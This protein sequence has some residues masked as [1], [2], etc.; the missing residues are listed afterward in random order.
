MRQ[1]VLKFGFLVL[2][3]LALLELARY[4]L[5]TRRIAEDGLTVIFAL[6]FIGVGWWL[7]RRFR[8]TVTNT[9]QGKT[10]QH[11]QIFSQ[12]K[13]KIIDQLG[14]S[15]RELEVLPLIA[16]GLSNQEIANRLFIAE[17]TVKSHVSNIM[18][19]LEVNRRTQA[20]KKARNLG[21]LV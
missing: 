10:L 2:A 12:S 7:S 3:I 19:K 16:D 9:K 18:L 11:P 15:K 20:V 14:L 17:S 5:F 8:R 6:I 4:S 1:I 21:I 13:E